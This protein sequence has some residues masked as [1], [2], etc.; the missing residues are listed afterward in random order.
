MKLGRYVGY[1][2]YF[3]LITICNPKNFQI[4]ADV[5]K[6][7]KISAKIAKNCHFCDVTGH[8]I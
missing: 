6:N 8:K 3:N 4:F 5:I 1:R 7:L 2:S